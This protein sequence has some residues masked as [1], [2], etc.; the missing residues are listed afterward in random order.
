M[1]NNGKDFRIS[2][3]EKINIDPVYVDMSMK[4]QVSSEYDEL[5]S[6]AAVARRG[7]GLSKDRMKQVNAKVD[8]IIRIAKKAIREY[9]AKKT[10]KRKEELK[11]IL[12]M[13]KKA[14]IIARDI[15][16][17]YMLDADAPEVEERRRLMTGWTR[18][19]AEKE[20]R[21]GN[22]INDIDIPIIDVDDL[23]SEDR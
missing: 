23:L 14:K 12:I 5:K 15:E 11:D 13:V 8:N 17:R 6:I 1:K 18:E 22:Q 10:E 21:K 4:G 19:Q 16:Y 2:G 7:Y 3:S 9:Q 20:G